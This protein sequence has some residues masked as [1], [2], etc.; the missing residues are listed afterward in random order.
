[1]NGLMSAKKKMENPL[2][3]KTL[4]TKASAHNFDITKPLLDLIAFL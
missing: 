4:Y 2:C 1:M 3:A